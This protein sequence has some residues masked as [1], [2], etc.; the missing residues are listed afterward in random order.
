MTADVMWTF[1]VYG[2]VLL[3]GWGEGVEAVFNFYSVQ[4]HG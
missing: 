1:D 3:F 2:C 4:A